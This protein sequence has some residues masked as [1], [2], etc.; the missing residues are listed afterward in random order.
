V[1]KSAPRHTSSRPSAVTLQ[2]GVTASSAISLRQQRIRQSKRTMIAEMTA[3]PLR[4]GRVHMPA[5]PV[6]R[7][8]VIQLSHRSRFPRGSP[9]PGRI[10]ISPFFSSRRVRRPTSSGR[11]CTRA[12]TNPIRSRRRRRR[13][14]RGVNRGRGGATRSRETL[15]EL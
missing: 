15:S 13:C 1:S 11:A 2:A 3:L 10:V 9:R 6:L 5:D 12:T 8:R 4:R 7:A 14:S